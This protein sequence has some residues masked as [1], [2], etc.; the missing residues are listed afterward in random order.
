MK[1][2]SRSRIISFTLAL[3]FILSINIVS[4]AQGINVEAPIYMNKS[5]VDNKTQVLLQDT[6][7]LNYKFQPQDISADKILP[8][9]Y[10]KPKE[11]VLI[12]DTSGSMAW[13]VNGNEIKNGYWGAWYVINK[14]QYIAN[15]DAYKREAN[16]EVSESSDWDVRVS[17]EVSKNKPYDYK[18][19]S[20]YYKYHYYQYTYYKR[21]WIDSLESRL[22]LAKKSAK[23][24]LKQLEG[25]ANVSVGIVEYNTD[26]TTKTYKSTSLLPVNNAANYNYLVSAI[27]SLEA[28]GGTNIGKGMYKGFQLLESGNANA[29]KYF[30]FLTDGAPTYYSYYDTNNNNSKDSNESFYTYEN[31]SRTPKLGGSGSSDPNSICLNYGIAVG[32]LMKNSSMNLESYFVAFADQ[33]AANK[34]ES[35]SKAANGHYKTAMSGNALESIYIDLAV[36]IGSDISISNI[37]FE[38]TF[39]AAFEI[40]S[41]PSNLT[42]VGNTIKGEFGSINY[43][44]NDAGTYF[45]ADSKDFTITLRAKAVGQYVLGA[46]QSSYIRYRDLDDKVK[47]KPF[48]ELSVNVYE[49]LPPVFTATLTNSETD[50][51]SFTLSI[52]LDEAS[53]L[54]VMNINNEVIG[55][56]PTAIVGVNTF[57]LTKEQLIGNYLQVQAT[58]RF[59]NKSL[60]TVPIINIISLEQKPLADLLL[61]TQLN[62]TIKSLLVN[63]VIKDENRLTNA[64]G[65]YLKEDL[66]LNEGENRLRV[67][68]AN[69]DGNSATLYFTQS[70]RLDNVAPIITPHYSQK[71]VVQSEGYLDLPIYVEFNGTGS[72][73]VETHF[74]E[75]PEGVTTA[76]LDTFA[77]LKGTNNGLLTAM[78]PAEIA[79]IDLFVVNEGKTEFKHEKF[80]VRHNGYYAIYARDEGGN[81]AVEVVKINNFIQHLPDLL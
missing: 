78:T 2:K 57:T 72:K 35:I 5:I 32:N 41:Y 61:Q 80:I 53:D 44:L 29:Q 75:L 38:E 39:P 3:I 15:N 36:Q 12:I 43:N 37:Y 51:N 69:A 52:D 58:D 13:D 23:N 56:N 49:D 1:I 16:I 31:A 42:K 11:I 76:N 60:E 21:D 74:V 14:S 4:M 6:F 70:L 46:N 68:A 9:N 20:K 22:E 17:V 45:V 7:T 28:G 64:Q 67:T 40:V 48:S 19:G 30:I 33:D 10:L 24:F 8:E 63:N 25:M 65:Q 62:S 34:L 81:E 47:V 79:A 66:P 26:T 50:L 73:I 55:S 59:N 71:F 27:N 18:S 54:K 77:S